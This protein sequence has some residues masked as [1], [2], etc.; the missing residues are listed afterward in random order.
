MKTT[1]PKPVHTGIKY[2]KLQG[3]IYS[4]CYNDKDWPDKHL[5]FKTKE[6]AEVYLKSKE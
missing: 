1:Q 5:N 2:S 3:W 6:E 4:K